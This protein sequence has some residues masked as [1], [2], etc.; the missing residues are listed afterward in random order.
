M[1][2]LRVIQLASFEGNIGD[3]A[4]HR[5]TRMLLSRNLD[6]Q[7]EFTNLEIRE[8]YWKKRKFD[9]SFV[10]LVNSHDLLIIGGGN[11]FELWVKNSATGT[12]IDMSSEIFNNIKTPILFYALGCDAGQ[13]APEENINKFKNFL[14]LVQSSGKCLIS[15]RNDGSME[16]IVKLLGPEYAQNIFRVPD[17]GFFTVVKESYHPELPRGKRVIGINIAGDMLDVRFGDNAREK[18]RISYN[19][20]IM[21]FAN[22]LNNRLKQDP[23]LNLVFFPHI[24]RDLSVITDILQSLEDIYRRTRVTVAPYLHGEG[25]QEYIFDIYAKC[26]LI[27]GMRFHANV[28]GIGLN[29]PTVGLINYPQIEYLYKELSLIER[30]VYVNKEG[31]TESLD[32]LIDQTLANPG[33]VKARY[34]IIMERLLDEA[35]SFHKVVNS[36]LKMKTKKNL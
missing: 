6:F 11:Y 9:Q 23:A 31:F 30:I 10:E 7:L 18:G 12:S 17:G 3:N 22:L 25:A 19:H 29:V 16:T 24:F 26:D 21:N 2:K 33:A 8:F 32:C 35:N 4:N 36:W 27:L 14:N 13:G 1:K 28:C 20:F 15:V 34:K 5:G